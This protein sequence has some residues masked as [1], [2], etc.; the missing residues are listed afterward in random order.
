[1]QVLKAMALCRKDLG[2]SEAVFVPETG[3]FQK[4]LL[5]FSYG[6]SKASAPLQG[7]IRIT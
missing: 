6:S 3:G 5:C 2:Q 7:L 1:M 4:E